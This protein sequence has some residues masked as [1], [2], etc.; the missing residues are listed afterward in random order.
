M[1]DPC[2]ALIGGRL[3]QIS[4]LDV[5]KTSAAGA[6]SYL[7][8]VDRPRGSIFDRNLERLT[9]R[10]A[11]YKAVLTATTRGEP[12]ALPMLFQGPRRG[13]IKFP[14]GEH[15]RYRYGACR[16]FGKGCRRF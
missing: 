2:F 12:G 4:L 10:D 8:T 13:N 11:V 6:S 9:N 5:Y 7:V 14:S 3:W 1:S 15:A 16:L